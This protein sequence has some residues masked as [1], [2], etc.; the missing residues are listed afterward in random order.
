M[1][2]VN[3]DGLLALKLEEIEIIYRRCRG[4]TVQKVANEM[5]IGASTIYNER[6][7]GILKLLEV[8]NWKELESLL[9][10]DLRRIIPRLEALQQGW[11]LAFREKIEALREPLPTQTTTGAQIPSATVVPS[12]NHTSSKTETNQ[13]LER[14]EAKPTRP[15]FPAWHVVAFALLTLCLL[16]VAGVVF[17]RPIIFRALNTDTPAP[18]ASQT[19][20]IEDTPTATF[21]PS[22]T[23][24]L[25][26]TQPAPPTV[27][28][29]LTLTFT[30]TPTI[31]TIPTDTKSPL[32][33]R[34][35]D[36]LEDARVSLRLIK[37]AYGEKYDKTGARFAPISYYFDFINHSE[38]TIVLQFDQYDFEN[39]DDRGQITNCWFYHISGAGPAVNEPLANGATRQIVARCGDG[40]LDP[41][42]DTFTLTVHPFSSLPESKWIVQIP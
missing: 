4:D 42:I 15:Q 39:Q 14:E 24:Q 20:Q 31:T 9:C 34:V 30:P 12:A 17:A 38:D 18:Q 27:T 37:V 22:P 16:C 26:E 36:V 32:D 11:P 35:G 8:D 13:T 7:P 19:L 41:A 23:F 21:E 28:S 5:G 1:K 33:L 3:I 25:T 29:T 2:K 10:V 40:Q 6:I